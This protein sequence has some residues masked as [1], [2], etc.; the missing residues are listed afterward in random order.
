MIYIKVI[1]KSVVIP[2]I[3]IEKHYNFFTMTRV[4]TKMLFKVSKEICWSTKQI[5]YTFH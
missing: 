4:I 5:L 3:L 1:T 2:N